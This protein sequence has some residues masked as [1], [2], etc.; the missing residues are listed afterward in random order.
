VG[1][2][3]LHPRD[4]RDAVGRRRRR[5]L[6]TG[7]KCGREGKRVRGRVW[8][9]ATAF[10]RLRCKQRVNRREAMGEVAKGH[11]DATLTRELEGIACVRERDRERERERERERGRE[12]EREG[13]QYR[14][15][16]REPASAERE[17]ESIG[18]FTH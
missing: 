7:V 12:R 8:G 4:C 11:V 18:M 6:P 2:H 17:R 10:A 3:M 14:V 13:H 5:V 9:R 1:E 15:S 16:E